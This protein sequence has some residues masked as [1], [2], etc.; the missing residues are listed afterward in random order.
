[1]AMD[2]GPG[3]P[4]LVLIGYSKGAPDVLEAIVTTRRSAP[5]WPPW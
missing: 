5:A 3:A 2:L 4:R 1:M